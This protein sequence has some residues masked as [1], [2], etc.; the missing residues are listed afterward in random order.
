M[1]WYIMTREIARDGVGTGK[2]RLT[3]YSDE[4]GGG[5]FGLCEHEHATAAEAD[6]CAEA[7]EAAT[8]Y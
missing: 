1:V 6:A 7:R 5:P 2:F 8:S 4:G 3:A